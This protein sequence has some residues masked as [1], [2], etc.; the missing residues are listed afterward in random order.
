MTTVELLFR[1]G[2]HP[3]SFNQ[4]ETINSNPPAPNR[5]LELMQES[6]R[7]KELSCAAVTFLG[8]L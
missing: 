4:A 7:L 3:A 5:K 2:I 1:N 8:I 6:Q